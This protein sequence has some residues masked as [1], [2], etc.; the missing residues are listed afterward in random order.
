MATIN[1][2]KLIDSLVCVRPGL[3]NKER[4][5]HSTSFTFKSNKVWTYNDMIAI[6]CPVDLGGVEGAILAEQFYALL[7][8]SNDKEISIDV[9]GGNL[10][11]KGGK[12][13]STFAIKQEELK[14]PMLEV[15]VN[16]TA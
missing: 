5:E 6:S 9:T 12:F 10:K 11:V 2:E 3:A 8:K 7:T 4:I 16:S 14:L 1:R 13:T 15:D